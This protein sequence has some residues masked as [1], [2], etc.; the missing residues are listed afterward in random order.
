[1]EKD[2]DGM[3][4]KGAHLRNYDST[5]CLVR[6]PKNKVAVIKDLKDYI[7]IDEEDVLLILPRDKEQEIKQIRND[8]E[9]GEETNKLV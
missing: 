2:E 3:V 7:V 5:N 6:L 4:F 1:M 9:K 8:L